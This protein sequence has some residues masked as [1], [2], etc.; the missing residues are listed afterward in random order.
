VS[1]N[2]VTSCSA[3][4]LFC[5][6]NVGAKGD[7]ASRSLEVKLSVQ[8]AHPENR[9]FTHADAV[10]WTEQHRGEI[11]KAVYTIMLGNPAL[12]LS[13]DA[14]MPT[15]FKDWYRLIGSGIEHG[16]KLCVE[17]GVIGAETVDFRALFIDQEQ[18]AEQLADSPA[19]ALTIVEEIYASLLKDEPTKHPNIAQGVASAI[20]LAGEGVSNE[21]R[22]RAETLAHWLYGEKGWQPGKSISS[23]SVGKKL[24]K[25]V[26]NIVTI[27]GSNEAIVLRSR[28]DPSAQGAKSGFI[29]WIERI[30]DP[31]PVEP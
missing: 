20:N 30:R 25:Q 28:K 15:R 31:D 1:R 7:S 14:P 13:R 12:G 21:A 5:G 6:N 10:L 16:A 4:H 18:D 9:N 22:E 26:D 2:A 3:V 17:A 19:Y 11:L 29:Y 8:H 24:V 27:P 23:K